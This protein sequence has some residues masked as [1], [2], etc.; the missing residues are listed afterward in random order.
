MVNF[1]NDLTFNIFN[2]KMAVA[3]LK[4]QASLDAIEYYNRLDSQRKPYPYFPFPQATV[5]IRTISDI[6]DATL[7]VCIT[8][9]VQN[10]PL[11]YSIQEA[12]TELAQPLHDRLYHVIS[13]ET[14]NRTLREGRGMY[15]L[16]GTVEVPFVVYTKG[17]GIVGFDNDALTNFRFDSQNW[18]YDWG[19]ENRIYGAAYLDEIR[20][21]FI[22]SLFIFINNVHASGARTKEDLLNLG[23][24]FPLGV[25]RFDGVSVALQKA[26]KELPPGF[27]RDNI[28]IGSVSMVVPSYTRTNIGDEKNVLDHMPQTLIRLWTHS[29]VATTP[30]GSHLQNFY[31]VPYHMFEKRSRR[32]AVDC[33]FDGR[34]MFTAQA[35][36][37]DLLVQSALPLFEGRWPSV[38]AISLETLY[39]EIMSGFYTHAAQ[40]RADVVFAEVRNL[41]G[42][43]SGS[44]FHEIGHALCDLSQ[45]PIIDYNELVR[46]VGYNLEQVH[47][48]DHTKSLKLFIDMAQE[49]GYE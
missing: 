49:R 21:E 41:L 27:N 5:D 32:H 16:H 37:T 40:W 25:V 26:I 10:L 43:S 4:L 17:S 14:L 36:N 1:I 42:L 48:D 39:T 45:D 13:T 24:S 35:D 19:R 6:S 30:S 7:E 33:V 3:K 44:S 8:D 9:I 12:V 18:F 28:N 20:C 47:Q 46:L 29:G 22:T 15:T 11:P 34:T 31:R 38:L 2:T 23:L